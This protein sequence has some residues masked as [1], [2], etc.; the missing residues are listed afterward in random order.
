MYIAGERGR[1]DTK[2]EDG[3]RRDGITHVV[4]RREEKGNG[5]AIL[6]LRQSVEPLIDATIHL[7]EL[8]RS[9]TFLHQWNKL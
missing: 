4:E 6:S 9:A 8:L 2:E 7:G 3:G 1:G 5:E